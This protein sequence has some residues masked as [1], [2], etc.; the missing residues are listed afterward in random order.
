MTVVLCLECQIFDFQSR[1]DIFHLR[2][3]T[4]MRKSH[5]VQSLV[6]RQ[7]LMRLLRWT[8]VRVCML[9]GNFAWS[10]HEWASGCRNHKATACCICVCECAC[11][12]VCVF[13]VVWT[14]DF[15]TESCMHSS[16]FSNKLIRYK[17]EAGK[18]NFLVVQWLR[19]LNVCDKHR[20]TLT[21]TSTTFRLWGPLQVF[22]LLT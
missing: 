1:M 20:C 8:K 17:S 16:Q 12:R 7:H 10:S 18:E 14:L 15:K 21:S 6:E 9:I 2:F 4:A 19:A 22:G 13:T 3:L 5:A 11:V